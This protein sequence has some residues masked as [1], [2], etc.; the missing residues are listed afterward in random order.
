[1]TRCLIIFVNIFLFFFVKCATAQTCPPNIDFEEGTFNHWTCIAGTIRLGDDGGDPAVITVAN[2]T[3]IANRHTIISAQSL[4]QS[5]RFGGFPVLCPNGSKYAVKIGNDIEG[6]DVNGVSY[7]L[8]V[9]A[10][11]DKYFFQY[12]Y[13]VVYE[14]PNHPRELQPRFEIFIRD[15]STGQ[16]IDCSSISFFPD[17]TDPGFH[18]SPLSNGNNNVLYKGWTASTLFLKGLGGKKVTVTFRVT[19]CAYSQHFGYAYIDVNSTC[20]QDFPGALFCAGD[21][22]V[23]VTGPEGYA[24]YAWFNN[25]MTQLLG[26]Q[27]TLQLSPAPATGTTLALV[28]QYFYKNYCKDTFYVN[29]SDTL[30]LVANAGAD[31]STCSGQAVQIGSKPKPGVR[32]SW[33]PAAGLS[34]ATIA[35]PR[36]NP[37]MPT[38]YIVTARSAGGGNCFATDTVFV[39]PALAVDTILKLN[40]KPVFCKGSG[41]SAVLFVQPLPNITW[42]RNGV[43]IPG[44]TQPRLPVTQ[45]GRY[46]ALLADNNGCSYKTSQQAIVVA[47]PVAGTRYQLQTI[48]KNFSYPLIA[49]K[50]GV[51]AS[52]NPSTFLDNP[53]SF[54]PVFNGTQDITY[55]IALSD[56]NGCSVTDTQVV[57]VVDKIEIYV[58]TGFTPNGDGLN[59]YL[60]PI[61][62]GMKELKYFKVFNRLGN[63]VFD[64]S[65]N[66]RG[67]DGLFQSVKL[68]NQV[69]VWMAEA[70]GIDGKT[71]QRK[72]TV[73]VIQ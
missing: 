58:P 23:N 65:W 33:M 63:Q 46:Y 68:D 66:V 44:A 29:L 22:T 6:G 45:S 36:A 18:I 50:I 28:T 21:S 32:Y 37:T 41:D 48:S 56:D 12:N 53:G 47:D 52:W 10:G 26:S 2:T 62:F 71:Y 8:Q 64:I 69:L 57:K 4:P 51:T 9:P 16:L 34:D 11:L 39:S 72:G 15:E 61:L 59:D 40:G 31:K 13:A 1:M 67:W 14:S 20:Q 24:S 3:P 30:N 43:S 60:K 49:R 70:I 25:N 55:T 27:Q 5:D 35:N 54:E 17:E 73:Q 7:E 38:R 42:F 19:G